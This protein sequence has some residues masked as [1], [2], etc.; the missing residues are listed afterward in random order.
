[1]LCHLER[2]LMVVCHLI[3]LGFLTFFIIFYFGQNVV[4]QK[5]SVSVPEWKVEEA[6]GQYGAL[7]VST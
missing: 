4:F 1:M 2:I 6:S 3:S 7:E 5:W